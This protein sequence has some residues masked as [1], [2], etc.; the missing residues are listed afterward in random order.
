MN[1]NITEVISLQW[2]IIE[3]GKKIFKCTFFIYIFKYYLYNKID[4]NL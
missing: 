2:K 1:D 3:Y 4:F